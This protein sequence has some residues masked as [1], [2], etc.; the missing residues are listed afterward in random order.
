MKFVRLIWKNAL[1]NRRRTALTILSIAVSIFLVSTLQAVLTS[2]Y[3]VGGE[4]QKGSPHLRVIVHRATSITQSM[5]EAYRARIASVPGAKYVMVQNWF[6]GVYID[7]RNFFANFAVDPDNFERVYDEFQVPPS[8]LAAWK[9]E[10]TAALVG[11]QLIDKFHWKIGDRITLKS[12]IYHINPEFI[13]RGIYKAT[14]EN[15]SAQE[16][17]FFF[18][19]EYLDELMGRPG[20]VG[21]FVVK[22]DSA[23]DVPR[24]IDS[25]D[26]L[27]RNTSAETKSETESAFGL[28]FVSMLGNVKLLLTGISAAVIFTILLVAGNTMAMSIRERTSEVAVLKTVGFRRNTILLLLVGESLVIALLG[29]LLGGA[30]AKLAYAFIQLTFLKLKVLGLLFGLGGAAL[31]AYG[32]W[33]LLAGLGKIVRVT[34]TVLAAVIGFAVAMA[35]YMGVGAVTT[36]GFFLA[37][38][39]V[40]MSTLGLCLL[41]AA[42]L[43][44]LSAFFPALRASRVRIAEAL[45]YVG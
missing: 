28:S 40:P 5:P 21:T 22:V 39:K 6:G 10:R 38:L 30:G 36:T 34:G 19:Y 44:F 16:S 27:F 25:I 20:Q 9:S 17:I 23:P 26:A 29:G 1:R 35:F 37:D 32:G 31:L 14:T 8:Q 42:L 4:G 41:I 43:G 12:S 7:Q 15:E 13:I 11:Q 24:V 45:R 33:M 18:H 3:K 2:I